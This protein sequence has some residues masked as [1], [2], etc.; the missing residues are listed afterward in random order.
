VIP[1]EILTD[2]PDRYRAIIVESGNPVHSLADSARWREAF[3]ALEFSVVIDVAMTETARCADYVLPAPTQYEKY[4]CTFFN[5]EFPENVFQLRRP[6]LEAPEG[7]LPEPEI[8]SR[9]VEALGAFDGVDLSPLHA[10]AAQGLPAYGAAFLEFLGAHP[11]LGRLNG[12]LLYRTLGPVL[13]DGAASAAILWG[14]AQQCALAHGPSIE[15]AGIHGEGTALGDALFEA[16]LANP[17]GV[18]FT[19]DEYDD[20]WR[21]VHGGTGVFEVDNPEM[22]EATAALASTPPP[23]SD[24]AFPLVLSAGE[25]R[26][27]TA[28][29]IMR[30]PGW[31]KK[32]ERGA[33]RISAEDAAALGLG[34][35][36]EARLTT[37]RGSARVVLEVTPMM[38]AGH[39]SLP[40]GYGLGPAGGDAV[41]V[42][43]NELTALDHRDPIAG[44]PLH[45]H[46]PARLERLRV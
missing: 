36:D 28:N 4:E 32:D 3:E 31:R 17:R 23:A 2:H 27:F 42:A 45:K 20:S 35:G 5:F 1:E 40:N 11:E 9:L 38:R 46:V 44:T 15:R 13:P 43:P 10:A 34:D 33:L 39:I 29:T 8:H 41:G 12:V 6:A 25:R 19:V 21:R 16:I 30:D 18:T 22:I 7:V 37:A 14:A 26:A 24:P